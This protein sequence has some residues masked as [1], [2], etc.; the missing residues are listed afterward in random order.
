MKI[1]ERIGA[2]VGWLFLVPAILVYMEWIFE[3]E[4]V[5]SYWGY[6]VLTAQAA[7][8]GALAWTAAFLFEIAIGRLVRK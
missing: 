2:G 4:P 1:A 7:V 3:G 8:L 5:H 6:F